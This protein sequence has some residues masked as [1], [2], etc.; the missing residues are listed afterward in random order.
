M[1]KIYAGYTPGYT[2]CF[3][4]ISPQVSPAV[5]LDNISGTVNVIVYHVGISYQVSVI[6]G[7][8]R[9]YVSRSYRV[10]E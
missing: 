5:D 6:T 4:K 8:H 3:E 2:Q 9:V 7:Q 10:V 1:A